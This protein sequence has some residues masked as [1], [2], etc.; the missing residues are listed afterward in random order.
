MERIY[1]RHRLAAVRRLWEDVCREVTIRHPD[2]NCEVTT[3]VDDDGD[4]ITINMR[5]WNLRDTADLDR[6]YSS[7]SEWEYRYMRSRTPMK[8]F[9]TKL[10]TAVW[11]GKELARIAIVGAW[12]L[13]IQHETLELVTRNLPHRNSVERVVDPHGYDQL[14]THINELMDRTFYCQSID[15]LVFTAAV[16]IGRREAEKIFVREALE[17]AVDVDV[18]ARWIREGGEWQ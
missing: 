3:F 2:P 12:A 14:G 18:E 6:R 8:T 7:M 5:M 11:P 1:D 9:T 10:R 4:H 16:A 13:Y 17:A 15:D